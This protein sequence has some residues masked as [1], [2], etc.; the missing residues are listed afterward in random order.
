MLPPPPS[1]DTFIPSSFVAARL[2]EFRPTSISLLRS[3]AKTV[4]LAEQIRWNYVYEAICLVFNKLDCDRPICMLSA[5][6]DGRSI[7]CHNALPVEEFSTGVNRA[8]CH[9][10]SR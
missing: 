5:G 3:Y 1:S 8:R 10:R 6:W 4:V 9:R 7:L 2:M